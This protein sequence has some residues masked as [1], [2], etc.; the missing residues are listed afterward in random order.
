MEL[1]DKKLLPKIENPDASFLA[2]KPEKPRA[3][4]APFEAR[5]SLL[6]VACVLVTALSA[7]VAGRDGN[8]AY[9]KM[10]HAYDERLQEQG[11]RSQLLA[12]ATRIE[13]QRA[14]KHTPSDGDLQAQVDLAKKADDSRDRAAQLIDA[15]EA[16]L[17]SQV[18][19]LRA[20]MLLSLAA[21]LAALASLWQRRLLWRCSLAFAALG[22]LF[23]LGGVL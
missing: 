10:Q 16:S 7:L 11:E 6:V 2:P 22:A 1:T 8:K 14:L 19:L 18:I 23:F 20:N 15:A 9:F 12:L 3:P 13:I 4:R 17:A 21:C 5:A